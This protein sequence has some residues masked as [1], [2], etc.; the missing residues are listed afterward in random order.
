MTFLNRGDISTLSLFHCAKKIALHF[1]SK[2]VSELSEGAGGLMGLNL[3]LHLQL[4]LAI[5]DFFFSISV[6]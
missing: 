5:N 3:L 6:I 1:Y 4:L 2:N